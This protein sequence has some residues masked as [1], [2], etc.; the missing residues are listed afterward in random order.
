MIGS[1]YGVA[2]C[3]HSFYLY[4][5]FMCC[6]KALLDAGC[7]SC[8]HF[9]VMP[10]YLVLLCIYF[11][12]YMV[13]YCIVY[14][15]VFL[16]LYFN[17]AC[18]NQCCVFFCVARCLACVIVCSRTLQLTGKIGVS[19]LEFPDVGIN[20]ARRRRMIFCVCILFKW[21]RRYTPY[22]L[23]GVMDFGLR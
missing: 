8:V 17:C 19:V 23:L 5:N 6:N 7:S 10:V 18:D 21:T 15:L 3:L 4:C 2:S 20:G 12:F 13:W 9:C 14:I 1:I 11:V 16:C 22:S